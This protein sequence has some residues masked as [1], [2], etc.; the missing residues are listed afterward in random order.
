MNLYVKSLVSLQEEVVQL[1]AKSQEDKHSKRRAESIAA[2]VIG[3][4]SVAEPSG[5]D[6]GPDP[7]ASLQS[8]DDSEGGA[9]SGLEGD[10]NSIKPR[11]KSVV[12]LSLYQFAR[13]T[14]SEKVASNDGNQTTQE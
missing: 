8:G 13:G 10:G 2:P 4:P 14:Y 3:R 1:E 5:E 11:L 9:G 12:R 7:P 6:R